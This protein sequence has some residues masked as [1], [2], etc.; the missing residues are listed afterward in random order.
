MQTIDEAIARQTDPPNLILKATLIEKLDQ[1]KGDRDVLLEQAFAAFGP[2]AT[3]NDFELSGTGSVH[4]SRV[5]R[6]DNT[7]LT[8]SV[9]GAETHR[10]RRLMTAYCRVPRTRSRGY[11]DELAHSSRRAD[12]HSE[13]GSGIE[14]RTAPSSTRIARLRQ[15]HR[16]ATPGAASD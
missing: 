10:N 13:S 8:M 4:S 9:S 15:D 12:P 2:L 16:P 1:P 7:R 6:R 3:L 11:R 5:T 14:S